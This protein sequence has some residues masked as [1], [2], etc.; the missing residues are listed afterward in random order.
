MAPRRVAGRLL[1]LALAVGLVVSGCGGGSS[2][3]S[4]SDSANAAPPS[5]K[6]RAERTT[7]KSP[8]RGD[9]SRHGRSHAHVDIPKGPPETGFTK[10]QR[11]EATVADIRLTSPVIHASTGSPGSIPRSYTCDGANTSP[12]LKWRGI[13]AGTAELALFVMNLQPVNGKLYFDWAVAGIDPA[14]AGLEAGR[15]PKGA[16]VG[17]N[18]SGHTGYSIC[19]AEGGAETYAL[20]LYALPKRLSPSGGFDP[21]ALRARAMKLSRRAGLMAASY[22]RQRSQSHLSALGKRGIEMRHIKSSAHHSP[23]TNQT[24]R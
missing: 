1:A 13:P 10:K 6:G 17:R 8:P 9:A 16:V 4:A 22:R 23:R 24:R 7:G 15:L 3:P 12:P 21:L 5:A 20:A 19:P 14:S 18:S 2:S 11:K